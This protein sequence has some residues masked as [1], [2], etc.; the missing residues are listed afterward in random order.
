M[1]SMTGLM[2]FGVLRY[3]HHPCKSDHL[4]GDNIKDQE[5]APLVF[6]VPYTARG[7]T[8]QE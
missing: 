5:I 8:A 1:G 6:H 7:L 3:A 4:R 2:S